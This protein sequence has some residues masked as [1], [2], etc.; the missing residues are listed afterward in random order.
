MIIWIYL[1]KVLKE[2]L[3]CIIYTLAYIFSGLICEYF[4]LEFY[5]LIFKFIVVLGDVKYIIER[6]YK[7]L[8]NI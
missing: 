5:L 3:G 7:F 2:L 8:V 6:L 4:Y 1:L